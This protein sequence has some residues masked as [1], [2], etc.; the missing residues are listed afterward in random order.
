VPRGIVDTLVVYVAKEME[1]AGRGPGGAARV[2]RR[3]ERWLAARVAVRRL[4]RYAARVLGA[5]RG[6]RLVPVA[7]GGLAID[8]DFAEELE[9]LERHWDAMRDI[10]LAEDAR[11]AASLDTGT[12]AIP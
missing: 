12:A 10:A 1:K 8:V 11:L 6:I 2:A 3:L 9:V 4:E 5:E 7:H